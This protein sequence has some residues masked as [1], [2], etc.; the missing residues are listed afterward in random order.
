LSRVLSVR[1]EGTF[2]MN[3]SVR[4]RRVAVSADGRGLVSQAGAVLLWETLRVTGLGRGLSAALEPWRAP[5]AVHDPGKIVAD[6]AAALALGGDCLADIAVLREQPDLAGPVASDPVV[7]RLVSS[8]AADGPRALAVIR[9][10]RAAARERAWALAGDAAP[11]AGGGLVTVDLDATIVIAHSEKQE[12]APT[13]KKTFGF[14]PMTAFA[15]HGA[16]GNGE[17]LALVL[18]AGSAGSNTAADHIEASRLALAQ[19]P[20]HLRRKVLIRADSGG[21][22]HG[23]LTWLTAKSRRLHYSAGMTVTE[24]MQDA[25]LEVPADS[26]TPAYDGDGQ[27]RDGAWVADITGMLDLSSWPAGMRVIVRKERPHPGA[28]LRFT[29]ID[30]HRFTAFATDTKKGQLAD[31]ELRHRRRA[32]CEDRIRNAKDTGLR[33]LPLK[34]FAQ[35]QLWCEI[36]AMAC[37]LLAWTQMLALAGAARCWEPKRLRLRLFSVAGR[38]ARGGR[39]LRLRL[40]A[41]WPWAGQITAAVTRL[42]TLP[43]G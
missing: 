38:L 33:N 13:W 16:D 6:L 37:E 41:R 29:D 5:R 43:S 1:A 4:S 7:S 32:R 40:A 14:H 26:W 11:G 39:R 17:P 25:I 31:L 36:T 24:E 28:Q 42:Q 21:G 18:R 10:A 35:N 30:G 2:Q 8:L 9:A 19:L 23:F 3:D 22:T 20:R 12:A 27:V 34:G 15:D